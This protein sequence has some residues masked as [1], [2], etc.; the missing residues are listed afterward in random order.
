MGQGVSKS[1]LPRC[2]ITPFFSLFR[3]IGFSYVS[4]PQALYSL[5][6]GV[7]IRGPMSYYIS[8]PQRINADFSL[9]WH[10]FRDFDRLFDHAFGNALYSTARHFDIEENE[11][12][13]VLTLALPGFKPGDLDVSLER[14][15]LTVRAKR[16]ER[17]Y[18]QSV[19]IPEGVD[20][21]KVEAKLEDGLLTVTLG[22]QAVAKPRKV[23]VK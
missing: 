12:A 2:Q 20:Q 1:R 21:D 4:D 14:E 7:H 10:S 6:H 3:P 9:G 17:S 13:Y 19:T 11:Q 16:D 22:K 8:L 23:T 15:T 5:A 18:E